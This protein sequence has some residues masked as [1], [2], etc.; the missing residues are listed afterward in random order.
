MAKLLLLAR[1]PPPLTIDTTLRLC[2][3]VHGR[4]R[5]V[6]AGLHA[7]HR[8]RGRERILPIRLPH[9]MSQVGDRLSRFITRP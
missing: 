9:L 4:I 5:E 6:P 2:C 3:S 1:S 7:M 8:V